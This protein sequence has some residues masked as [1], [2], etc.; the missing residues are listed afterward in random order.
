MTKIVRSMIIQAFD[1]LFQGISAVKSAIA[2]LDD[3][4]MGV[5][6]IKIDNQF[7]EVVVH[8]FNIDRFIKIFP[9]HKTRPMKPND[10][11]HSHLLE[12]EINGM[13]IITVRSVEKEVG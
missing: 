6:D 9:V 4:G 13:K 11:G 1:D 3:C 7:H 10:Y 12:A 8:V 2:D 5:I